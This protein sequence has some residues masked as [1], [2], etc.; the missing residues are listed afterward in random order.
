MKKFLGILALSAVVGTALVVLRED[1]NAMPPPPKQ[2]VSVVCDG[3]IQCC[4][5]TGMTAQGPRQ[6]VY[7]VKVPGGGLVSVTSIDVGTHDGNIADYLNLVRPA[8]WSL[9]ILPGSPPDPGNVC[10]NH[11]GVSAINGMCPYILHFSGPAK[12]SNF[13]LAYDFALNWDIHDANWQASNGNHALWTSPV[14]L[15]Q[16]PV[17]SPKM[18]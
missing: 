6:F 16:G 12:T 1:A 18:Q 5:G 8:G 3:S 15:G 4:N 2:V 17:H 13:T 10:T 9:S 14:G 7:N 11:G